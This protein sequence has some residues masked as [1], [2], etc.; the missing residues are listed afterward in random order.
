MMRNHAEEKR[1]KAR[2]LIDYKK[3]NDNTA[4]D[5]CYIRNGIVFFNRIQRAPWF[6]KIDHI[7]GC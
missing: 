1:E 7:S 2:I 5:G 3:F 4:F 6:S